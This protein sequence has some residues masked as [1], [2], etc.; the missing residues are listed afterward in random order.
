M[1]PEV[2]IISTEKPVVGS[3]VSSW[4]MMIEEWEKNI[5]I[6]LFIPTCSYWFLSDVRF[7]D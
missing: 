5:L 6:Q 7:L 3:F 2:M 4:M 1:N